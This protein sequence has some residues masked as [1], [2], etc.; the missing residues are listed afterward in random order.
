V[1]TYRYCISCEAYV[2]RGEGGDGRCPQCRE[3][4][5]PLPTWIRPERK[6]TGPELADLKR[7]RGLWSQQRGL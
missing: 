6:L 3:R 5:I 7:T 2:L 4:A 1:I